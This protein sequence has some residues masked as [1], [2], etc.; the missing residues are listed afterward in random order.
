MSLMLTLVSASGLVDLALKGAAVM[1]L[2]WAVADRISAKRRPAAE[3]HEVPAAAPGAM[4]DLIAVVGGL[5]VYAGIVFWAH[6]W[7]FGVSPLP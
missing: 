6:R 7:L 2:A 1:L 3:A 4:N 5:A